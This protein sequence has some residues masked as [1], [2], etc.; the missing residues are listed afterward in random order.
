MR[1]GMSREDEGGNRREVLKGQ[2]LLAVTS[3]WETGM[4]QI[5]PQSPKGSNPGA[6]P[7][8]QQLSLHVLLQ[9]PGVRQFR[10]WVRT[11]HHLARHAG[12]GIPHI[13]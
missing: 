3:S 9:W 6:S 11:W 2:E 13:K 8:P 12:A 7:V 5:L 10:S 1:R 4:Q